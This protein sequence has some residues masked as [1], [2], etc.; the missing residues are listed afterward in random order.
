MFAQINREIMQKTTINFKVKDNTDKI[1]S[2]RATIIRICY[3]IE[4]LIINSKLQG[5]LRTRTTKIM[6]N[7]QNSFFAIIDCAFRTVVKKVNKIFKKDNKIVN[8]VNTIVKKTNQTIKKYYPVIRGYCSLKNSS[9][10]VAN[11]S[12]RVRISPT[13][14]NIWQIKT[15]V[16]LLISFNAL[17]I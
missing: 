15:P 14:I 3:R 2:L 11:N 16:F 10:I 5:N 6:W 1:V 4:I 7:V 9:K 17:D 8:N 13:L 12:K